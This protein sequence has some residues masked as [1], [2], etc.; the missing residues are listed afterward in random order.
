MKML[1]TLKPYLVTGAVAL[2]AI[3]TL[4]TVANRTR[5]GRSARN[6]IQRGI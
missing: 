3:F 1:K 2:G 6:L 4:N 5:V